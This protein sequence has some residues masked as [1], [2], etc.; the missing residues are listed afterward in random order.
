MRKEY[1]PWEFSG[2]AWAAAQ[3][4]IE[5]LDKGD[6]AKVREELGRL[7]EEYHILNKVNELTE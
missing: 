7:I 3:N 4:A 5:A 6:T 1:S 2:F